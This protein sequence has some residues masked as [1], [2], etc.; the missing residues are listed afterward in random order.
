[1]PVAGCGRAGR[2]LRWRL[3]AGVDAVADLRVL[4]ACCGG[5][6]ARAD[7]AWP[8]ISTGDAALTTIAVP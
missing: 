3:R 2:G 5:G 8:G 1:M 6:R 7:E 4:V